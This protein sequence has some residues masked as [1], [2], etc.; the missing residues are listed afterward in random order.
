MVYLHS[1]CVANDT[2]PV[3]TFLFFIITAFEEHRAVV[4]LVQVTC[5]RLI[6]SLILFFLD[7]L[8]SVTASVSDAV[9]IYAGNCILKK[10]LF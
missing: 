9:K 4:R 1:T 7:F 3:S 6:T 10:Q 8:R 5:E 2:R